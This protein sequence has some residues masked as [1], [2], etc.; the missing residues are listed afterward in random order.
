MKCDVARLSVAA[1]SL[2]A[3][4]VRVAATGWRRRGCRYLANRS[5]TAPRDATRDTA[6]FSPSS[7]I[8]LNGLEELRLS[9]IT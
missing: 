8:F 3:V 6:A 7:T 4:S 1:V 2:V 5:A 9:F